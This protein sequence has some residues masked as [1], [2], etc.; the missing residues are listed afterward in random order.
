MALT[1]SNW[2]SLGLLLI[3]GIGIAI[4][5]YKGYGTTKSII[6]LAITIVVIIILAFGLSWYH[7][8]TA[9]GA[10]AMKDYQSNLNNGIDRHLSIVANDGTIIYEREGKFDIEV[11]E[12]YIIFDE[13]HERTIL[14]KSVTSTLIIEETGN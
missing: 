3:I 4:Y 7:T 5:F 1:I 2:L 6:T 9:D 10:R 12:D 11:H 14:Y 13:N 8:N